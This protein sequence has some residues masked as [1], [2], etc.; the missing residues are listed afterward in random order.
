MTQRPLENAFK[1]QFS[2]GLGGGKKLVLLIK[3]GER[4]FAERY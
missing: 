1:M 4:N 3:N 2:D